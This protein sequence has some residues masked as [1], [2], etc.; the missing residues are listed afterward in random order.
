MFTYVDNVVYVLPVLYYLGRTLG[1]T[2]SSLWICCVYFTANLCRYYEV[3]LE[4]HGCL[5]VCRVLM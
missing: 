5:T 4:E 1:S 3:E 2:V